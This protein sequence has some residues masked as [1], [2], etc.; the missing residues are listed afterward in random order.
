M[1]DTDIMVDTENNNSEEL[2]GRII[3]EL[4]TFD[5]PYQPLSVILQDTCEY[6]G[7]GG[8]FIYEAD[9]TDAFRLHETYFCYDPLIPQQF[10][11]GRLLDSREIAEISAHSRKFVYAGNGS[12]DI[13]RKFAEFFEA[14][15]LILLPVRGDNGQLAGIV[16]MID[17]RAIIRLAK[18]EI[19][20]AHSILA[21]LATHV[22]LRIYQQKLE[23]TKESLISITDN[24]GVDIYVN[25][26][27]THE[28]LFANKS[29]AAPYGG[30]AQMIGKRCWELL[31]DDKSG[32]CEYCPQLKL[33]DET[34]NP[35]KIYSWDYQRP[36]DGHWF[37]VL[38]AAFRWVDGRLAHIVSSIDIDENKKNEELVSHLADYD[39]LTTIPNRRRMERD[40]THA[41]EQAERLGS[42]MYILFF[43][44]DN[45][46]KINDTLGHRG[47]DE[48]LSNIGRFL[49][50]EPLTRERTY[51]HAGDEFLTICENC[52]YDEITTVVETLR[53]RFKESWPL[54][55][56]PLVCNISIGIS[57]Y[58]ENGKN[59]DELIHAADTA[60]YKVK[61]SGKDNIAFA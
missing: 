15:T 11:L 56:A 16:G 48:L 25:D 42:S 19:E 45:F 53:S 24:M 14:K 23:F 8:G 32:Q 37:R 49:Q 50:T 51:R 59:M 40:F 6:F 18:L 36:F 39:L 27:N 43:D 46:K 55:N 61:R 52:T 3:R 5:T 26:F 47:G 33:I 58:P 21:L 60:M 41:L 10:D 1:V 57:K 34:G 38:S 2:F 17:R 54:T 20:N 35:S 22:K 13:A 4:S 30:V 7:M 44:I 31:Y 12:H 28:V 9:H 29:M